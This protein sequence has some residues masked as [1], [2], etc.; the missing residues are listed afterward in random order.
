MVDSSI[1]TS[2]IEQIHLHL[3]KLTPYLML[4]YK[5]FLNDSIAQDV[6]EYNVFQMVN[7]T[8]DIIQHIV[9][10]EDYGIPE[11]AYD[12]VKL[13]VQKN[14]ITQAHLELLRK[15]IGF[16]N[17]IGHDYCRIDKSV[18]YDILKNGLLDIKK[19]IGLF[20]KKYL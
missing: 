1:I 13:L 5:E 9:V 2:R 19:I 15:M 20:S 16:R 17:V 12:A 8:I 11:S 4:T 18:V 14:I 6:V 10:D 7:H 3:S